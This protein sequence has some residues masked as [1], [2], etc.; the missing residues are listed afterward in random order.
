MGGTGNGGEVCRNMMSLNDWGN[1]WNSFG[2]A[3]TPRYGKWD[4]VSGRD[5]A[6][7][8]DRWDSVSGKATS[9]RYDRW[10]SS[11]SKY[12]GGS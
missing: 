9:P 11:T 1:L 7:R 2:W 6:P 3:T 12:G 10:D 8:Y 4:G 5:N